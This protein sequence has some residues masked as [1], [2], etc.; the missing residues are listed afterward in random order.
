MTHIPTPEELKQERRNASAAAEAANVP[1]EVTQF[2]N[3][4]VAAM[5]RGYNYISVQTS[6]PSPAAEAQLRNNFAASGYKLTFSP[7]RT[8]GSIS[9]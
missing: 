8:G 1:N 3:E 4:I 6:M 2:T 5:R 9:W 7:R